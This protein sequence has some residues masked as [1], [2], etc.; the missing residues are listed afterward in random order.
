M[1]TIFSGRLSRL[2]KPVSED[3]EQ[4]N[5][6]YILNILLVAALVLFAVFGLVII[7]YG[8]H[9]AHNHYST[10]RLLGVAVVLLIL[11]CLLA[12]SKLGRSKLAA[13]FLVVGF[14]AI[15]IHLI[16]SQNIYIPQG[17]LF[18]AFTIVMS[19]ILISSRASFIVAGISTLLMFI[20]L[21]LHTYG[22]VEPD[23]S[24]YKIPP[25]IGDVVGYSAMFFAITVVSWLLYREMKRSLD[26]ARNS[27][28]KYKELSETLEIK[29]R[30]RANELHELQT[31]K[32]NQLYRFAE[33]GHTTTALF[34]DLANRITVLSMD[35]ASLGEVKDGPSDLIEQTNDSIK[36]IEDMIKQVR[37][38]AQGH[39]TPT[40][41]NIS[42]ETRDIVES[43]SYKHRRQNVEISIQTS[44]SSQSRYHG[45]RIVYRQII[46][47]VISNAIDSY[48]DPVENAGVKRYVIVKLIRSGRTIKVIVS[49]HGRGIDPKDLNVIFEPFY[50]TKKSGMGIG[51]FI[52]KQLAEHQLGGSLTV[53]S[54]LGAGSTFTL[55]LPKK[56]NGKQS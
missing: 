39:E 16:Y 3:Q 9:I 30:K 25:G 5:K 1:K 53:Q 11:S 48:T 45:D 43:L 19:G 4:R 51:L 56:N 2:V 38:Q 27:E 23:T 7:I 37:S 15:S 34:H 49:D 6:E 29:A 42:R 55:A 24:W 52:A 12:L 28:Q 41:F 31:D 50:S 36:Y 33:L 14:L 44:I 46:G 8:M 17:V 18:F 21:G 32:L 26:K 47:S 35:V 20:V 22:I 40:H 13:V 10:M 54:E